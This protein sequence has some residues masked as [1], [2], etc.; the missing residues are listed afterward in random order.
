MTKIYAFVIFLYKTGIFIAAVFG[1]KKARLWIEGRKNWEKKL[2]ES[3]GINASKRLWFHCASLGEFEQGRP[4]IEKIKVQ[5]PEVFIVLTFFSP[6]GFEIRKSYPGADVV[7]YLPADS[8][9]NAK[10]FINIVSPAY[11]V[12]VKYEFWYHYFR[13][14]FRKNI[15]VYIVSAIFRN[16]QVFFQWYGMFYRKLLKYVTHFFVQDENSKSLL[17]SIGFNNVLV[18]GDTRFD[19]VAENLT[20]VKGNEIIELFSSNHKV[21]IAGSSWAEDEKILLAALRQFQKERIK[22]IIAPHE[23]SPKRIKEVTDIV[24]LYYKE[25][26][27]TFYSRN[28]DPRA[29]VMIIDNIGILSSI[30]KYAGIVWIGGGFGKGIHNI[31]E[32]AVFGKPVLFG[33][34]N[35]K[36]KE[37][38][39]LISLSGAF[40]VKNISDASNILGEL[41]N[42]TKKY[43]E[44]SLVAASFVN[45]RTG[46]S[47]KIIQ[48]IHPV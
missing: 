22:L 45:S 15:P 21:I 46:A 31:L 5:N 42:D 25:S 17:R 18:T 40:E 1:N 6:S 4:L 29:S 30:Y 35:K 11:I 44:S 3:L 43:S 20:S 2:T 23:I 34:V 9:Q 39:D 8:M 37:A 33:P 41:L 47:D 26:Q 16:S 19:R 7:C 14:A 27:I 13:E 36:F 12:F 28:P 38:V 48:V 10:R 24:Q 32:A